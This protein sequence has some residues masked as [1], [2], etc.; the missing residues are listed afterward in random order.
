[1]ADLRFDCDDFATAITKYNEIA[2]DLRSTKDT[3]V[4]KMAD[5]K[6]CWQSDAGVAFDSFYNE[7]WVAHVDLYVSVLEQLAE[8]LKQ[9]SQE[10]K[11]LE[12]K[13]PDIYK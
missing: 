13:I 1:M 9:A 8:L 10:Y 11:T 7:N 5:L 12:T 2:T 6:S 4:K 3:L